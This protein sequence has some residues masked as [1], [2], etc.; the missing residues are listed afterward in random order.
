VADETVEVKSRK[1]NHGLDYFYSSIEGQPIAGICF[2]GM[3]LVNVQ[4]GVSYFSGDYTIC[5]VAKIYQA[6]I[7]NNF[8]TLKSVFWTLN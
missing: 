7:H 8:I 5:L 6:N 3:S 1:K 2:F 4:S